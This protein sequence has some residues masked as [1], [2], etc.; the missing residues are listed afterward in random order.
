MVEPDLDWTFPF[1]RPLLRRRPSAKSRRRVFVLGAAPGA[2]HIA[3]WSP[4]R[5]S[6][7]ALPVDNEPASFWAGADEK[8]QIDAWRKAVG[9]RPG[10][11]GEVE[12]ADESNGKAGRWLDDHVLSALG[13][14]RDEV[15]LST[16]VDTY[17]AD[18]PAAFAVRERYAPVALEAGLPPAQLPPRPRDGDLVELAITTHRER[19]LREL[20][21]TVPE[22]VVTLGNPALRVLRAITETKAGPGKL[23]PDARYGVHQTIGWGTR[24]AVW[25]ALTHH[26]ADRVF[27]E[28]HERWRLSR[29]SRL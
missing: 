10:E 20:S 7:K 18:A 14:T 13:V 3:W 24:K 21:M 12:T 28:A 16:C 11:W 25:L 22:I 17:F 4:A 1:G 26:E 2:L 8:A 29:L 5:K 15:C 6:V 27:A 19:L 9:F 23:H